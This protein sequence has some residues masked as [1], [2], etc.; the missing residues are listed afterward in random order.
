[1]A[2]DPAFNVIGPGQVGT[3][4]MVVPRFVRAALTGQPYI[5]Y[6]SGEQLRSFCDVRAFVN[7]LL[8]LDAAWAAGRTAHNIYN[9]GTATET[10][11]AG[12][13][14][15]ID[16]AL[17][18]TNARRH[19]PFAEVYPGKQDVARRRPGLDRIHALLG[20]LAWP[21]LTESV[22]AVADSIRAEHCEPQDV[23]AAK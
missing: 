18:V 15:T 16:G 8:A 14:D 12:L 19:I 11:V 21:S 9:I 4:G 22:L 20:S 17:G 2:G 10:S 5:I 6:G 3:Y 7:H 23:V 1:M 13:A